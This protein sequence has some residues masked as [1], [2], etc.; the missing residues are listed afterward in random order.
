MELDSLNMP[1][2]Y[3]HRTLSV[4]CIVVSLNRN[5]ATAIQSGGHVG[6]GGKVAGATKTAKPCS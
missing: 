6:G 4:K 1:R 2:S 3:G 5:S